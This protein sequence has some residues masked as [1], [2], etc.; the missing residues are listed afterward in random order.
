M[1]QV[2]E[3]VK[4]D[5]W[6]EFLN[7]CEA[8]TIYHTPAWKKLLE[9][10][11]NYEPHYLFVLNG[12]GRITGLLP[13]FRVN[14]KITGNRLCSVPFSH[15]C[16]FVGEKEALAAVLDKVFTL[17][18]RLNV[19]YI[20]IRESITTHDFNTS[21]TFCDHILELSPDPETVW[22]KLKGAVRNK[23]RKAYKRGV[24]V[25]VTRSP[26][27]LRKFYE[28]NC[29][30]KR[31]I[32]VPAHPWRFLENI[33]TLLKDYTSLYVSKYDG[34]I[35]GGGILICYKSNALYAYGCAHP[36]YLKLYPYY[37][38]LWKCIE[39]SCLGG[40]QH[41][42]LGRSEYSNSG[43]INFK[44]RWGVTEKPLYYSYYPQNP[45]SLVRDRDSFK[46]RLATGIIG[47]MPIS[48]YKKLS[49]ITYG[50]FG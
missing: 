8:A 9:A 36:E 19:D 34:R 32:G 5:Q 20:E 43:L 1:T 11:F 15:N 46:F 45:R 4:E 38:Y 12:S 21:N 35:I 39:D 37:A 41:Y 6:T 48:I 25:E 26:G 18:R 27:D 17:Y 30:N 3:A 23:I 49:D 28:L 2:V 33:F 14:S 40:Y 47:R 7:K 42:D 24:S 44:K 10:T 29:L 22:K 13:L 16:G 31:R 50:H